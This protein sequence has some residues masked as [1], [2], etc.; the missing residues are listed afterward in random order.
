MNSLLLERDLLYA[1]DNVL[2]PGCI[3]V[4]ILNPTNS[5]MPIVVEPKSGHSAVDN[6]DAILDIMQYD[7][8]GRI[9]VNIQENGAV[10]ITLNDKDKASFGNVPFVKVIFKA[11]D[12]IEFEPCDTIEA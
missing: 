1:T 6:I 2:D 11:E 12:E 5:K 3:H 8:F 7:I 9:K 4:K 10:Y